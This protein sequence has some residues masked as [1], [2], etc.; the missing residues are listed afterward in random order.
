LP[1]YRFHETSAIRPACRCPTFSPP[2]PWPISPTCLSLPPPTHTTSPW[3]VLCPRLASCPTLC[4]APQGLAVVP[5]CRPSP[6]PFS[7]TL[8]AHPPTS[9][10]LCRRTLLP[11]S[12]FVGAPTF[13]SGRVLR[14]IPVLAFCVRLTFRT[15]LLSPARLCYVV[16]HAVLS[17]C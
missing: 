16:H 15:V 3:L 11:L 17:R 8:S 9:L 5:A 14:A 12:H 1:S 6:L 7:R 13:L 4:R 10:A 2:S